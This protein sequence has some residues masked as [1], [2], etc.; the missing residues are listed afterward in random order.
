[1]NKEN[2]IA[3]DT[4]GNESDLGDVTDV[5]ESDS[6]VIDE[7]LQERLI[8]KGNSDVPIHLGMI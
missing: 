2:E 5:A 4:A 6:E 8:S 7:D 1:M 3:E